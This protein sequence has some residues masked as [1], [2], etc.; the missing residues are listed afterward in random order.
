MKFPF[1]V[2]FVIAVL[3]LSAGCGGDDDDSGSP[4]P[5]DDS[6]D[7]SADDDSS[8][9]DTD[10]DSGDDDTWPPLPD[11]D[12][13]GPDPLAIVHE[14]PPVAEPGEA[15]TYTFA[16]Q[17]GVEPYLG[18]AVVDGELP[19][20][21]SLDAATGVLTGTPLDDDET[22]YLFVVEATD[23]STEPQTAR[24]A[25]GIRVGDPT[26]DGPLLKRARAYQEVYLARHNSDG[27]TVTADN[28]DDVGGDYWFSDLGDACFIH[29]NASAG[30]AFRY[31]VEQTEDA[32]DNVRTHVRGLDLLNRVNGVPGLLSRSY[33]PKDAPMA[34]NEFTQF[35]PV[36]DDHEGEGEFAD[37][38]WKGDVSI[39]QYSG[40][41][42]GLATTYD[43]VPDEDVRAD[44]RR[45]VEE[46]ADHMWDNDFRIIDA[47]GAPT[48]FGDFRCFSLEGWPVPNG[49]TSAAS[50]AW[51]RLAGRVSDE[52]RFGE[53]YQDLVARGCPNNVERFLWVYLGYET[54]HYNVYMGFEN[55]YVLTSLEDGPALREQY[56]AGFRNLLWESGDGLAWRRGGVEENPT[57]TSWYLSST[58]ERDPGAVIRAIRQMDVF[59]DA[60]LRDRY[61]QNSANPDI[62]VNPEKTDWALDPLPANLRIPDMCI[63]HR[64]PYGLDG[65][66]DNGR[67]RSGHDYMLPYWMMRHLGWIGPEW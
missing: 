38:Y 22:L 67:E 42:V 58:G 35:W 39:D 41:L 62:E 63:W 2:L 36:N 53:Y 40:E 64:S 24:E 66:D 11:D 49:L 20:G 56:I 5:D 29:G 48:Q 43:L 61:I 17:G 32:L 28:P 31:A 30:A 52:P 37:Y 59:V 27:L 4:T 16:A 23:S 33:M 19:E 15:Y 9:D 1:R 25:F 34:P 26:E 7:D 50:L 21:L 44:I 57:F 45:T 12:T 8:D 55:M 10:D 60:P 3:T 54:K 6:D 47:D 18:W 51:M 14:F 46:V 65:G 13:D